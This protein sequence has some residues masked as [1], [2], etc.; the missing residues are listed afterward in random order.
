M[1]SASFNDAELAE[2]K[3]RADDLELSISAYIRLQC[4]DVAPKMRAS[5]KPTVDRIELAR[6]LGHIGHVGGNL[7]Q[8]AHQM[9]M[10]KTPSPSA[11]TKALNAIVEMHEDCARALGK[12]DD[13]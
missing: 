1:R 11:L 9:N 7:N 4:L 12:V 3:R 2:L 8:I 6:L 10:R 5:R 13:N